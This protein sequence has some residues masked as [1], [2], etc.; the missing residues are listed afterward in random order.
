MAYCVAVFGRLVCRPI[1]V[2]WFWSSNGLL[3][4]SL[5]SFS[6]L[7]DIGQ[8]VGVDLE[9]LGSGAF[10]NL[11]RQFIELFSCRFRLR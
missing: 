2:R 5:R 1:S 3:C 10:N 4:R 6:V 8:Q 7:T 9:S 11:L